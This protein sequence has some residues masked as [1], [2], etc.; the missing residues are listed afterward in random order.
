L[1]IDSTPYKKPDPRLVSRIM[2]KRPSDII[3][4]VV[5]GDGINDILLANNSGALSCVF[6][7]RN[8]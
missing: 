7:K 3:E 2:E 4:E 5:L 8:N 6:L 1:G